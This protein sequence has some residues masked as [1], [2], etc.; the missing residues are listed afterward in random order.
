MKKLKAWALRK[1]TTPPDFVVGEVGSPYLKRWYVWPRNRFCNL[2]LHLFLRSDDDRALHDHPWLFN[3]SLVLAG[4]YKEHTIINGGTHVVTPRE[5]GAFKFRWGKS[6]HRVALLARPKNSV[7]TLFFTGPVVREW[8]F[9]CPKKWIPWQQ[10]V[11]LRKGGN[12]NGPG[13]GQ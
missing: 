12:Q 3:A 4:T 6:P 11:S 7:I 10:F 1:V 9:Y 2:Y 8:G 13:C 5:P